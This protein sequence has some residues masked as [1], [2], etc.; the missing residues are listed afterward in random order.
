MSTTSEDEAPM[1]VSFKQALKDEKNKRKQAPIKKVT[2]PKQKPANQPKPSV[3]ISNQLQELLDEDLEM[4]EEEKLRERMTKVQR[5]ER[6][7]TVVNINSAWDK[8]EQKISSNMKVV[9][10]KESPVI[11]RNEKYTGMR[12]SILMRDSL[13]RRPISALK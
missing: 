7:S 10:I 11:G 9:C 4:E 12:A 5:A 8:K 2:K 3:K 13:R 1:E 6:T